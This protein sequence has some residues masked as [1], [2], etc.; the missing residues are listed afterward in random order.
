[1]NCVKKKEYEDRMMKE[2]SNKDATSTLYKDIKKK[3][4]WT[5]SWF[6]IHYYSKRSCPVYCEYAN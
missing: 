3:E 1:M 5:S 2:R 6:F 4:C